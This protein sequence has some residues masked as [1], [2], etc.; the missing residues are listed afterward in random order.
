MISSKV[1]RLLVDLNR[2]EGHPHHFSIITRTWSQADRQ[3]LIDR[4]YTP[5]RHL[6]EGT[7]RRRVDAGERVV[8]VSVHS[9]TPVLN[10]RPRRGDVGFLYD[11]SRRGEV[12][13]VKRWME[14]VQS[15]QPGLL[16]RRNYPYRGVSDGLTTY[17]RGHWGDR[18]YAGI[19]LEVNQS[20]PLGPAAAWR[21]LRRNL[22]AALAGVL[23]GH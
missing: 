10:G 17:L 20:F 13:F 6:V 12:E 5:Y 15:R 11:P 1:S 18:V 4:H 23:E 9:F 22:V 8:H 7:I 21:E 16:L 14:G 3:K 2:S 19:E